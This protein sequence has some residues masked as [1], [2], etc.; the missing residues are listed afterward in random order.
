MQI[1]M[2]IY[3]YTIY[4]YIYTP[5]IYIYG[6][7]YLYVYIYMHVSYIDVTLLKI[8][9]IG[10]ACWKKA[11]N[12]LGSTFQQSNKSLLASRDCQSLEN[13][14]SGYSS[15]RWRKRQGPICRGIWWLW[16]M[17]LLDVHARHCAEIGSHSS[18]VS[19][20]YNI[21][22]HM[23]YTYIYIII[24]TYIYSIPIRLVNESRS[25]SWKADQLINGR[26]SVVPRSLLSWFITPVTLVYNIRNIVQL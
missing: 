6:Y 19:Y 18:Y 22:T 2:Y 12:S 26:R 1:H 3:I 25:P 4:V 23:L 17:F 14:V 20:I 11:C 8:K 10:T 24:Y 9:H 13:M 21:Y 5:C 16:L 15:W 7:V